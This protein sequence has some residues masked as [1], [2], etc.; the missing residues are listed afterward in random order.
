MTELEFNE[1][2]KNETIYDKFKITNNLFLDIPNIIGCNKVSNIFIIYFTNNDGK[3]QEIGII[4]NEE[5]AFE[6]LYRILLS[7]LDLQNEDQKVKKKMHNK[8]N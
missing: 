1:T 5:Y 3:I 8:I 7:Q 6:F 4:D 2:C